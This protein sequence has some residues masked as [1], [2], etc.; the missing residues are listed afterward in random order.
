MELSDLQPERPPRRKA[1]VV[2]SYDYCDA[3]GKLLYQVER[4]DDKSFIQ[5]RPD[6]AGGWIYN[7][8]GVELVPYR[9]PEIAAAPKDKPILIAEGEKDVDNLRKLG[10]LAT[11]NA[12]G[13][14]KWTK[15]LST[16]LKGRYVVLLPDNDIAG[17]DH[18]HSVAKSLMGVARS[19]RLLKLPG[20]APKGDAS[21][22]I[23][24]G[25]T[26]DGLWELIAPLKEWREGLP[27]IVITGRHQR[28]IAND[29]RSALR[30]YSDDDRLFRFG[31]GDTCAGVLVERCGGDALRQV[32]SVTAMRELLSRAASWAS[33][34]GKSLAPV[35]VPRTAADDVVSNPPK[36]PRLDIAAPVRAPFFSISGNLISRRGYVAEQGVY[37]SPTVTV[38]RPPMSPTVADLSSAL[39]LILDE[40]LVD[41]PF[42]TQSDRAH[43]LC[44]LLHPL[45]RPMIEGPTPLYVIESSTPGTG[46]GLLANVV[47]IIATGATAAPTALPKKREGG[48]LR[49]K[50]T[51]LLMS[52]QA[53]IVLDNAEAL[54]DSDL[55]AALTADQWSD[56]VLGSSSTVSVPN[57]ALWIVTGNNLR[58]STEMVRR[59]LRIRIVAHVERPE[60]RSGFRHDPLPCWALR[61]RSALLRALMTV[62]Q[63]WVAAGK[64]PG[65]ERMGSYEQY[66]TVMGGILRSA[67]I[68]GMLANRAA[69]RES[70]DDDS[71]IWRDFFGA[72][73]DQYGDKEVTAAELYE[74]AKSCELADTIAAPTERGARSR[75]GRALRKQIDRVY[76]GRRLSARLI[77]GK[78]RYCI[79]AMNGKSG[80]SDPIGNYDTNVMSTT[81]GELF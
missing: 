68:E 33:Q 7:R 76:G 30:D 8:K 77:S 13:A 16:W 25:G 78:T 14:G 24:A 2:A 37:C 21:D 42:A 75:L 70:A 5:R 74:L 73:A 41:F 9:L 80:H 63:S 23:A 67:G 18:A 59:C 46:K 26:A 6:A 20:L 54:T 36:L 11:C 50:I 35:S 45:V 44:L 79:M 53:I 55:A 15:G 22:W 31:A 47:S 62:V 56:R 71:A 28:D 34:R 69:L 57:R 43:A 4:R 48:E 12:G 51:S 39:Q 3:E 72:V 65:A 58:L 10:L 52:G 81:E 27:T 1:R 49:K 61:R 32:S 40:L 17:L 60:E 29:A 19:I 64:Q 66:A 38:Q